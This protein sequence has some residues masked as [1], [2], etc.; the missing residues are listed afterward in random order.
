MDTGVIQSSETRSSGQSQAWNLRILCLIDLREVSPM[1]SGML[2][3]PSLEKGW[4]GDEENWGQLCTEGLQ[5]REGAST[6]ERW[7]STQVPSVY[8]MPGKV[9][10]SPAGEQAEQ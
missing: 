1:S 2:G 9:S 5:L 7:H 8:R 10:S 4:A 3:S 6:M